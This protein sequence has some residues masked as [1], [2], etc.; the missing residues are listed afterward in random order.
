MVVMSPLRK[1]VYGVAFAALGVLLAYGGAQLTLWFAIA[2]PLHAETI[3]T[4]GGWVIGL[5]VC[6]LS[7]YPMFRLY[8]LVR[9]K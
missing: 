5:S 6:I 3:R 7:L 4:V 9:G 1:F 2:Y 8:G